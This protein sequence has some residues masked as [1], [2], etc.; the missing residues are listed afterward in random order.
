MHPVWRNNSQDWNLN[1]FSGQFVA[2]VDM[3]TV[4][5]LSFAIATV[6]SCKR[7]QETERLNPVFRQGYLKSLRIFG[8]VISLEAIRY[9][10]PKEQRE[11]FPGRQLTFALDSIPPSSR[12]NGGEKVK[13]PKEH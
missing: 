7:S 12:R 11:L 6:L 13:L 10:P 9:R 5:P 3:A 1:K 2:L 8:S 4:I